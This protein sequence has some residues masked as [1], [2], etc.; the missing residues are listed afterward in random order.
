M[1][2]KLPCALFGLVLVLN[3]SA[4]AQCTWCTSV[5]DACCDGQHSSTDY[6]LPCA[7]STIYYHY[8]GTANNEV[9]ILIYNVTGGSEVFVVSNV[10]TEICDC[11]R[12]Q[13]YSGA[14]IASG[15][16]LRF[17]VN[18]KGCD[19]TCDNGKIT[20]RFFTPST[21]NCAPICVG[22]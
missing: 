15:D 17:K 20:V 2:W 7:T 8:N 12:T 9:E 4:F 19:E 21:N 22:S 1:N 5:T 3:V 14:T 11:A 13:I 10:G 18:C 16:I 6:T